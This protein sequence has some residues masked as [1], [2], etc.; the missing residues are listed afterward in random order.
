MNRCLVTAKTS[1]DPIR[2]R[3][4]SVNSSRL[5]ESRSQSKS[6]IPK[7]PILGVNPGTRKK[8]KL[9]SKNKESGNSSLSED[10]VILTLNDMLKPMMATP[11]KPASKNPSNNFFNQR[12]AKD[13]F[14][15]KR[16]ELS[17]RLYPTN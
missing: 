14:L 6:F 1:R 13:S 7:P 15:S 4:V 3:K 10:S 11:N 16:K 9:I 12:T 8:T 17:S 2:I 5:H